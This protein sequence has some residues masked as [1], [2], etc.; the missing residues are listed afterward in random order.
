MATLTT[1][2][3]RQ[4]EASKR[5]SV[6]INGRLIGYSM[7]SQFRLI[8]GRTASLSHDA[9]LFL[10]NRGDKDAHG[11]KFIKL[12]YRTTPKQHEE[13]PSEFFEDSRQRSFNVTREDTCGESTESFIRGV[14]PEGKEWEA[15]NKTRAPN[16]IH[17]PGAENVSLPEGKTLRCYSFDGESFTR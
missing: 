4:Q 16:L 12:Q 8:S 11:G 10:V 9:F 1:G 7:L 6:S 14:G 2:G 13:L 17:L 3:A 5:E 15:V